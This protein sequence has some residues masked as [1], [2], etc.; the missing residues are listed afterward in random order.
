MDKR[1][2]RS[3]IR[4]IKML[5]VVVG[6]L[7]FLVASAY[8]HSERPDAK[9]VLRQEMHTW[10]T[11][12]AFWMREYIVASIAG[13]EETATIRER[14]LRNL[15]DFGF[16]VAQFYGIESSNKFADLFQAH[17]LIAFEVVEAAKSGDKAK[18]AAAD[19]KWH[20]N[21]ADIVAF[22]NKLNPKYWP[23]ECLSDTWNQH[24]SLMMD[25]ITA[26]L[27]KNWKDDISAFD[28]DFGHILGLAECFADGIIKQFSSKFHSASSK[29]H[30]R[31]LTKTV[32][33]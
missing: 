11:S 18:W 15:E 2:R 14:L 25:E 28:K 23:K 29:D 7:A 30:Q 24:L 10:W 26:R 16:A 32:R 19:K 1:A 8:A 21:G 13:N 33:V 20:E 22:L 31:F 4:R 5:L 9:S 6:I 27:Q 3:L 12:Y 17:A